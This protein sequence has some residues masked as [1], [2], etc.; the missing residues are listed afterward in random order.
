MLIDRGK[1]VTLFCAAVL[2][3]EHLLAVV[4]GLLGW[5]LVEGCFFPVFELA[6]LPVTL[7]V[8]TAL[9]LGIGW[10]RILIVIVLGITIVALLVFGGYGLTHGYPVFALGVTAIRVVVYMA[11]FGVLTLSRS[12]SF[13]FS[14]YSH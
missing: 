13:Y 5:I 4:L 12:V 3:A 6:T 9:Y 10:A 14:Y 11:I 1:Y 2:A 8:V 7:V